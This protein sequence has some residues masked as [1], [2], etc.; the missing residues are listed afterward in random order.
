MLMSVMVKD[1]VDLLCLESKEQVDQGS[2]SVLLYADDTLLVGLSEPGLQE[3][4]A[5]VGLRY[6]MELHWQKFQLLEVNCSMK[7]Q[8]PDGERIH[9]RELLTYLGTSIYND[10]RVANELSKKLGTA[11]AD[12]KKLHKLWNHTTFSKHRKVEVYQ[13]VIVSRLLYGLSSAWLNVA[14]TRRLN[15]FQARCLRCIVG[16]KPSYVSR[17]SNATVLSNAGQV[18]VSRLLLRQQLALYGRIARSP[19]GDYLRGLTF[20]PGS[21][22]PAADRY[23]RRVGRPRNEW[24]TMLRKESFK[25]H[26]NADKIVHNISQWQCTVSRLIV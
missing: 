10:G 5:E 6:G 17:V 2:L 13:A 4:I 21:V 16:I 22:Q 1:S 11:W 20:I 15:G 19:P 8:T 26:S 25:M 23:I 12:F 24:P 7:L 9:P 14:E 3:L 18:Q